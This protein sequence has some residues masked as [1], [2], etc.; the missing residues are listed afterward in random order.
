MRILRAAV[1][2][3]VLTPACVLGQRKIRLVKQTTPAF[4]K[5][6]SSASPTVQA[7]I[8][9]HYWRMQV[10]SPYFDSKTTWYPNGW[11]YLDAYAIYATPPSGWEDIA[12]THPEWILKDRWGN[13]LYIPWD[14]DTLQRT[15]PQ[16]A[17]DF[18]NAHY[19]SYWLQKAKDYLARGAYGGL[20]IDDVNLDFDVGDGEG[21]PI[22]PVDLNT[23]ATMTENNWRR[24]FAGFVEDIRRAFPGVEIVHNSVWYSGGPELDSN[25]YVQRQIAAA[26][27]INIEHGVNDP[28]LTGGAGPWSLEALLSFIERVNSRGKGVVLGGIGGASGDPAAVEFG[29]AC[30]FLI[31]D[32]RNAAGDPGAVTSPDF[33]PAAFDLDLGSALGT[34]T[35]WNGLHRR[36]FESGLVL[37]NPPGAPAASV[38]FRQSYR[39]LDGT[40]VQ[41]LILKPRQGAILLKSTSR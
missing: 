6:L 32:G 8:R 4:E 30:Y 12:M 35:K 36:D 20:W 26:D 23:G 37:V 33:L 28:N 31:S 5:Y 7:W 2:T 38:S 22:T 39:R 11:I 9:Q 19:R 18:S 41:S 10:Y 13:R 29:L 24:Y 17:A 21:K 27:F 40:T 1:I 14:C 25:P 34:R 15:C 3:A 16:Y